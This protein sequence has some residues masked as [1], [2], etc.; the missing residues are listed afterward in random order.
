MA[1]LLQIMRRVDVEG[2]HLLMPKGLRILK[3]GTG[4]GRLL[5]ES[6][7]RRT[8]LAV[9]YEDD[10]SVID[11]KERLVRML[12]PQGFSEPESTV[13]RQGAVT[14][15][16]DGYERLV[17]KYSEYKGVRWFEWWLCLHPQPNAILEVDITGP[18]L[19]SECE[20]LW[21]EVVRSI[22]LDPDFKPAPLP[23]KPTARV[24]IGTD[25]NMFAIGP[26]KLKLAA[27][28]FSIK[29]ELEQGFSAGSD[30]VFVAM[31]GESLECDVQVEFRKRAPDFTNAVQAFSVPLAVAKDD[32]LY[33]HVV[34]GPVAPLRIKR[35]NYDMVVRLVQGDDALHWRATLTFLRRGTLGV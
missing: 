26:Q 30:Y 14:L 18:G 4:C 29:G 21:T 33:V 22:R 25:H 24:S 32:D 10:P 23:P 3:F 27:A 1:T 12:P 19:F 20:R 34:S 5:A 13:V 11:N 9:A 6:A 8:S 15:P 35:G 16:Y 31:P 2:L 28:P 17:Q 7:D